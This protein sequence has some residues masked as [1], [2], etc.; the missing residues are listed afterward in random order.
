MPCIPADAG[1]VT[2]TG[3]SAS[4]SLLSTQQFT[5]SNGSVVSTMPLYAEQQTKLWRLRRNQ[6]IQAAAYALQN[7]TTGPGA[8]MRCWIC[9]GVNA[10]SFF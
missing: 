2:A 3:V 1:A 4:L 6:T 5:G 7:T 9:L 8:G 10:V